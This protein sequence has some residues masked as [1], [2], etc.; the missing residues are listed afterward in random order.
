[1]TVVN[2]SDGSD[3]HGSK[4]QRYCEVTALP[5]ATA[6]LYQAVVLFTKLIALSGGQHTC[7]ERSIRLANDQQ[8]RL[9]T[10]V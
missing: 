8:I 4:S 3:G 6:D 5:H 9:D 10:T 1:M 2:G 7:A